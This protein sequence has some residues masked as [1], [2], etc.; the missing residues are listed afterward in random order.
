VA[1]PPEYA[2]KDG[3]VQYVKAKSPEAVLVLLTHDHGN[4]IGDYFEMLQALSAAGVPVKTVGQSDLMRKGLVPQLKAANLA[5]SQIVVNSGAGINFGGTAK[6]GD[7][8]VRL[9]PAIHSTLLR[10]PSAGFIRDIGG[11]RAY[12]SGDTDLY[13]DLKMLGERYRPHLGIF[14]V[15]DGPF[16]MGPEDAA[17]A[18][19]WMGVSQAVPVHFAHNPLVLGTQAGEEFHR[20]VSSIAAHVTVNVMKPGDT[21]QIRA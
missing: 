20:A 14:C 9:V 3:F 16:T 8:T 17:R 11:V 18:C 19:Q 13:G 1:K 5:P 12:L 7:M 2:S 21:R 6:F 4:H 10:F 15:G